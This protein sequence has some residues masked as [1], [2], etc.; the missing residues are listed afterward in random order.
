[1]KWNQMDG[2]VNRKSLLYEYKIE[3][4]YPLNPIGRTGL[5][6]RGLLGENIRQN[7]IFI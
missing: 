4:G 6:G 5:R 7:E 1:M 3:D 2:K